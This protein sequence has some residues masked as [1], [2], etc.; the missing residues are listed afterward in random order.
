MI[1][2]L[3]SSHAWLSS[4]RFPLPLGPVALLPFVLWWRWAASLGLYV[5]VEVLWDL[6]VGGHPR[7]DLHMFLQTLKGLGTS[8]SF[9]LNSQLKS[10]QTTQ[11]VRLE[12]SNPVRAAFVLQIFRVDIFPSSLSTSFRDRQFPIRVFWRR[13]LYCRLIHILVGSS[14][15]ALSEDSYLIHRLEWYLGFLSCLLYPLRPWKLRL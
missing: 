15:H 9:N 10:F 14:F 13:Q 12:T 4:R 6:A 8:S 1:R 3:T 5:F 2:W 11:V 7:T